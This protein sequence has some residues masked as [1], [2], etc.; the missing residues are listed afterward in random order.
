MTK[1]VL[2]LWCWLM[3]LACL[4]SAF[5]VAYWAS[6]VLIGLA[7]LAVGSGVGYAPIARWRRERGYWKA[8]QQAARAEWV[9]PEAAP[10]RQEERAA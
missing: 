2:V 3:G 7:L 8:N 5:S 6:M 9:G 10:T 4:G 1:C